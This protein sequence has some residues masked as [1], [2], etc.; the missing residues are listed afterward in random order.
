MGHHYSFLSMLP[1]GFPALTLQVLSWGPDEKVLGGGQPTE[2]DTWQ[3]RTIQPQ[4]LSWR[5]HTQWGR[6]PVDG[7]HGPAGLV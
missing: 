2:R 4:Y 6:G 1:G 5:L 3:M 7:L